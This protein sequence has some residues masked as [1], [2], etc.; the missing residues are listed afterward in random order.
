M[1]VQRNKRDHDAMSLF[2]D[3]D[4]ETGDKEDCYEHDDEG[5]LYAG[6]TTG[7]ATEEAIFEYEDED[8]ATAGKEACRKASEKKIRNLST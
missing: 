5:S 8:D 1:K 6:S 3:S 2:S 7:D 4:D